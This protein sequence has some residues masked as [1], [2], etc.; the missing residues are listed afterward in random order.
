MAFYKTVSSHQ[1]FD[2][3]SE[4]RKANWL[5]VAY[6][7]SG[8]VESPDP[9]PTLTYESWI[10]SNREWM[11]RLPDFHPTEEFRF[12]LYGNRFSDLDAD[13]HVLPDYAVRSVS[14]F[15]LLSWK[16]RP[17]HAAYFKEDLRELPT[18]VE[19]FEDNLHLPEPALFTVTKAIYRILG[20][21]SEAIYP[22]K[23]VEAAYES[24]W[25]LC[26]GFSDVVLCKIL[27][28]VYGFP[29]AAR[30]ATKRKNEPLITRTQFFAIQQAL[31]KPDYLDLNWEGG[32]LAEWPYMYIAN[33][34]RESERLEESWDHA[35]RSKKGYWYG[36]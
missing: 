2:L 35:K 28:E 34:E 17:G 12:A 16:F 31:L 4:Y 9:Q 33:K 3:V 19:E 14:V 6:R 5:I 13:H 8:D 29:E 24:L 25:S 21:G 20:K 36:R 7:L 22:Y 26:G 32:D 27:F 10:N 1:V 23:R 15:N 18:K 11:S 30:H